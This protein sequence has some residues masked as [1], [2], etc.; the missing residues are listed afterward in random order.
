[1]ELHLHVLGEEG[2]EAGGAQDVEDR[3]QNVED[4]QLVPQQSHEGAWEVLQLWQLGIGT[5]SCSNGVQCGVR[6]EAAAQREILLTLELL[7]RLTQSQR[8]VG[9]RPW[10]V[11]DPGQLFGKESD[12]PGEQA[13]QGA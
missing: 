12:E 5:G 11:V 3:R 13:H 8:Q 4:Q 6:G 1:V 10:R 9:V 7:L 2:H